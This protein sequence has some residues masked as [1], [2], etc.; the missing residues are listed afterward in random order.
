MLSKQNVTAY[1]RVEKIP[2]KLWDALCQSADFALTTSMLALTQRARPKTARFFLC[3]NQLALGAVPL[4]L[5]EETTSGSCVLHPDLMLSRL[6]GVRREQGW[7]GAAD[8]LPTAIPG[9]HQPTATRVLLNRQQALREALLAQGYV[10]FPGSWLAHLEIRWP[11]FA[12]YLAAL[13]GHQRR[14][15]RWER[16]KVA[17]GLTLETVPLCEEMVPQLE[18]LKL[19]LERK[20]H[21][22]TTALPPLAQSVLA[23]AAR[24]RP[25]EPLVTLA[26]KA[27]EIVGFALAYRYH[28]ELYCEQPGFDYILIAGSHLYFEIAFYQPIDYAITH[29]MRRLHYGPEAAR[30]R[31]RAARDVRALL[32]ARNAAPAGATGRQVRQAGERAAMNS[33][34][35]STVHTQLETLGAALFGTADAGAGARMDLLRRLPR[36]S[37]GRAASG[38][39][40]YRCQLCSLTSLGRGR[41]YQRYLAAGLCSLWRVRARRGGLAGLGCAPRP[42]GHRRPGAGARS[43]GVEQ[44]CRPRPGCPDLISAWQT[45]GRGRRRADCGQPA[46][47]GGCAYLSERRVRL[48][49]AQGRPGY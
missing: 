49:R 43:R 30:L 2:D 44:H 28:D 19:N 14:I 29:R 47:G 39:G 31:H 24:E 5:I 20:Y 38:P 10:C 12:G 23:L 1:A 6:A 9:S 18:A 8:M 33:I 3:Q 42:P 45:A 7:P 35:H 17:A 37:A 36:A 26:R 11:D 27:A 22:E 25:G 48:G 46:G 4:Y 21:G 32:R 15:V 41:V 40:R 13:S 16:R 34:V